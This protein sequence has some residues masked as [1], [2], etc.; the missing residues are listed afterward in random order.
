MTIQ[1][2]A[3]LAGGLVFADYQQ[4]QGNSALCNFLRQERDEGGLRGLTGGTGYG[5]LCQQFD[6]PPLP[7]PDSDTVPFG[8]VPCRLYQVTY[9]SGDSQGN[10]STSVQNLRGPIAMT[11]ITGTNPDGTNFRRYLLQGGTGVNCPLQQFTAASSSNT[12][13][14]D[15]EATILSITPLEGVGE[16][17]Q[18]IPV[19]PDEPLPRPP[20]GFNF[21]IN[22]NFGGLD[23]NTDIRFEAPI[24]N[25]FGL[26]I[27]FTIRPEFNFRLPIDI[28]VNGN[29]RFGLNLDLDLVIPLGGGPG[30]ANPLPNTQPVPLPRGPELNE[31]PEVEIDYERIE[32]AIEDAKCCKPITDT[33]PI[34]T[35]TFETPNDVF[36]IPLPDNAVAVFIS[37]IQGDNTR[38]YKFAGPNAEFGHGN[39]SITTTNRVISFERIYTNNH[40]LLVPFELVDKGLRLSLKQGSIAVVTA[41]LFV[42]IEAP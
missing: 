23:I 26:F 40:A 7:P 24:F 13:V 2:A 33:D 25:T 15:V 19:P 21:E 16:P 37:I 36:N 38:A 42:P 32:D 31:C 17:D 3:A 1:A 41:G 14:I 20:F 27:P 11:Q 29:P 35:F 9:R 34:G 10:S 39:A 12:A 30:G 18:P 28:N 22:A 4:N 6:D 8:G 5:L